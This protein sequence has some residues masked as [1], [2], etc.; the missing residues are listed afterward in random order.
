MKVRVTMTETLHA[1]K[2][3]ELA[4]QINLIRNLKDAMAGETQIKKCIP[5]Y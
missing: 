4:G 5:T 3:L 1:M 2:E